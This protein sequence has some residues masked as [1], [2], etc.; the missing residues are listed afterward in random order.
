M[1]KEFLANFLNG[2]FTYQTQKLDK[3]DKSAVATPATLNVL[4]L[5]T[6]FGITRWSIHS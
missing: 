5:S 6:V 3:V 2:F 4:V 1:L